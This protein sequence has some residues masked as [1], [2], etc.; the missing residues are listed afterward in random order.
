MKHFAKSRI[1]VGVSALMAGTPAALATDI[2]GTPNRCTAINCGATRLTGTVNTIVLEGVTLTVPWLAS[3]NA[4]AGEC[5]R[6]E[7]LVANQDL[8]TVVI[9]PDGSMWR[10]DDSIGNRPIVSFV[11][12]MSGWYSVQV[13]HFA[14]S[15]VKSLFAMAYGRYTSPANPNCGSSTP[16]VSVAQKS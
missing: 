5:I 16:P 6:L 8:E 11:A 1:V 15:T 12:P 3:V 14:G 7:V 13:A 4:R 9:A 10:D 2:V